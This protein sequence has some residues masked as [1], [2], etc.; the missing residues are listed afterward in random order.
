[1]SKYKNIVGYD[2][3]YAISED[4][5]V[6]SK[7]SNKIRKT[8][9]VQ[10]SK[11][12]VYEKVIL[13]YGKPRKKRSVF[14][15]RLIAEAFIPNPESKPFVNH[16]DSDG[17]NNHVTNLEWCTHKENVIHSQLKGRMGMS[18][19]H[20]KKIASDL[21]TKSDEYI[22]TLLGKNFIDFIYTKT[23]TGHPKKLVTL[24]C[25]ICSVQRTVTAHKTTLDKSKGLCRK[26]T[27]LKMKI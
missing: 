2:D 17:L 4:G 27:Q 10:S 6:F 15:H 12:V 20:C 1:M 13:F 21:R 22:K 25:P 5:K 7:L 11:E 26:C 18:E 8:V 9:I 24:K 14:V 3:R 19:T 23:S 16:I